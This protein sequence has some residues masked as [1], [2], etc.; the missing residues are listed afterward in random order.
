MAVLTEQLPGIGIQIDHHGRVIHGVSVGAPLIGSTLDKT[1]VFED[2]VKRTFT[3][4]APNGVPV[5]TV[6]FDSTDGP[7]FIPS[8]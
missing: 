3:T 8:D 6:V 5:E 1:E 7:P 4:E 2:G